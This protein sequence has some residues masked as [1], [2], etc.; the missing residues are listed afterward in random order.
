MRVISL[1]TQ[2]FVIAIIS[3][4]AVLYLAYSIAVRFADSPIGVAERTDV[5]II[6]AGATTADIGRSLQ[7]QGFIRS[8]VL[9]R[10]LVDRRG[11]DGK[12][13]Q[14]SYLLRRDMSLEEILQNFSSGTVVEQTVTFPEGWRIEE[15]AA[16]LGEQTHIDPAEFLRL[17]RSDGAAF[18]AEFAFLRE[19][20]APPSLEGYLFPDTYR[21]S[22]QTTARDLVVRMLRRFDEVI[23][24]TLRTAG[25]R[26]GITLHEALTLASIIE[27]E[28][29]LDEERALISGVLHNRLDQNIP[30]QVDATV[31]YAIGQTTT[32]GRWWK[33]DITRDD[34]RFASP[35]NTYT[36]MGIPPGPIASPGLK[37]I[38][39]AVGPARTTF[40]FYVAR[41]DGSHAFSETLEEHE[42]NIQ[43]YL[44]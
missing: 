14:G 40:L 42:R 27:R 39:A 6:P 29:V 10:L 16:R 41:G 4:A 11:L 25:A 32:G 18:A 24:Q 8:D 21:I 22:E 20:A 9:F 17:V 12:L 13:R 23:D 26:Y 19:P 35:Y 31:Q 2:T 36:V 44:R 3:F 1:L 33:P 7:D 28:A 30:L 37:S 34:L 15:M 43:L 38:E 5:F